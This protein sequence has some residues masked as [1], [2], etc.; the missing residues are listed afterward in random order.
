MIAEAYRKALANC[1][2]LQL[3]LF[4]T[5]SE[6]QFLKTCIQY[7]IVFMQFAIFL[8]TFFVILDGLQILNLL[9]ARQQPEEA[10]QRKLRVDWYSTC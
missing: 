9:T 6:V 4:P 1:T 2:A 10:P 3:N 5:P 7:F 8:K